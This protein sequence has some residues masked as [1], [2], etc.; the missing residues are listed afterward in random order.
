MSCHIGEHRGVAGEVDR[1]LVGQ[2]QH[3]A[4]RLAAIQNLIAIL[5]AATV[6]RVR[7]GCFQR[8]QHILR[9]AFIHAAAG[10]HAF[11]SQPHASLKIATT[12]GLN[13]LANGT[14]S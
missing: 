9:S 5:D 2:M 14:A 1:A 4:R 6:D 13:F 10:L 8:T 7:H 12:F 3:V 11:G